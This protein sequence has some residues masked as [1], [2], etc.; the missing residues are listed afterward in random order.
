MSRMRI[1]THNAVWIG[2]YYNMYNIMRA[3]AAA[4]TPAAPTDAAGRSIRER[5][6]AV[7]TKF[8]YPR[9]YTLT[10]RTHNNIII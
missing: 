4:D 3:A 9:N 1:R 6:C 10:R 7:C 8:A 2:D 5:V